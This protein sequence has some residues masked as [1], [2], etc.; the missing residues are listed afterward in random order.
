MNRVKFSGIILAAGSGKR[1]NSDIPKQY[2][3]LDKKPIVYYTLKAFE[4][5]IVDEIILV[6]PEG[7]ISYVKT[8]I[9]EKNGLKKVT[10]IV[11]GGSERIWSVKNGIEASKGQFVLIHDGARAFVTPD[12]INKMAEAA[13]T[14]KSAIAAVPAKDTIK[15]SDKKGYVNST[16]DRNT[17]WIVQT[18]QA[19]QRQELIEAY[20]RLDEASVISKYVTDDAG[21]MEAAGAPVKLVMGEYTNIKVTTP[22]DLAVGKAI[23]ASRSN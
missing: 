4:E 21:I 7:D 16:P 14:Y 13:E 17:L 10:Q 5:S 8:D 22:E 9:I 3:E 20:D 2:M 15:V 12:L 1:M 11:P 19:F 18:P 6:V 23:L